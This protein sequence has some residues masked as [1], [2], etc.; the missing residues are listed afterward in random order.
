MGTFRYW[1][2]GAPHLLFCCF[3]EDEGKNYET[4]EML[5]PIKWVKGP[6]KWMIQLR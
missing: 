1:F 6:K 4:K 5:A 2:G 3:A